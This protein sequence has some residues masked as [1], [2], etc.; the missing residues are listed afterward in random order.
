MMIQTGYSHPFAFVTCAYAGLVWAK[1]CLLMIYWYTSLQLLE[2]CWCRG[3]LLV[4]LICL[5]CS[6]WQAWD[7]WFAS[8]AYW[9]RLNSCGCSS[10]SCCA[11]CSWVFLPWW[12]LSMNWLG[13][14]V[15]NIYTGPLHASLGRQHKSSHFGDSSLAMCVWH[16]CSTP[17]LAVEHALKLGELLVC[18][19]M[20]LGLWDGSAR[21]IFD[22]ILSITFYLLTCQVA[23]PLGIMLWL[24]CVC[25][26]IKKMIKR[27]SRSY[28]NRSSWSLLV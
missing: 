13:F 10:Y 12:C 25:A 21:L 9:N 26:G 3:F 28:W 8:V 1:P 16:A 11:C 5:S 24:F 17:W 7:A 27:N 19:C 22:H 14:V 4:W 20:R 6:S 18:V 23:M 2:M 15:N